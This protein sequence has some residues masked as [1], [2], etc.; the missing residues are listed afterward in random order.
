[1]RIAKSLFDFGRRARSLVMLAIFLLETLLVAPAAMARD[2]F[3]TRLTPVNTPTVFYFHSHVVDCAGVSG[4]H[5]ARRATVVVPER[6]LHGDIT[7][8]EG[9]APVRRCQGRTGL[10]TIVTYTPERNFTGVDTFKLRILFEL[11]HHIELGNLSA[12]VQVGGPG[13]PR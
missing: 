10:A 13:N 1:M 11:S 8:R 5:L 4:I 12:R 3:V 2:A 9:Q 6:P 7:I